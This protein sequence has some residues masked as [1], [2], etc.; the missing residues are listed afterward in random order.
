MNPETLRTKFQSGMDYATFRD[1]AER[2]RKHY[3]K[4][5]EVLNVPQEDVATFT[6]L[7][8]RH[9]GQLNVLALAEDW[10]GD[11]VRALP[12]LANVADVVD[13]LKLRILR[14]A[15][16][17]NE[18]LAKRWPKGDRN[19]IPIVVFF[20]R[21]FNEIGHWIERSE[22]G[23][24]YLAELKE[25]FKDLEGKPLSKKTGPKMMDAFKT[26]FWQDTLQEWQAVLNVKEKQ[27]A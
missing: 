20:D 24:V 23:T 25:E 5:Y 17:E 4:L 2:N 27:A 14:S 10:C 21:D 15:I 9:G 12:L 13:G 1:K 16:E 22:P 26:R 6:E 3:E 7:V 8:Q 11:A 19:P 18:P